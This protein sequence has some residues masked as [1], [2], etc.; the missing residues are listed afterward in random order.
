MIRLLIKVLTVL[1]IGV[2]A[3]LVAGVVAHYAF[4][5]RVMLDGGGG[6]H[7][8][9]PASADEQARAIAAHREAQRAAAGA[10][11]T[12][13]PPPATPAI[14]SSA[15]TP[16]APESAPSAPASSSGD[17]T[18]FRGPARDGVY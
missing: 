17:W 10:A 13:A 12:P 11:A 6:P 7:L 16:G 3:V 14:E 5:M 4:G 9:F 15:S 8:R 1:A 18:G 2:F